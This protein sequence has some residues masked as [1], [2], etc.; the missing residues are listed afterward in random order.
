MSTITKA[1]KVSDTVGNTGVDCEVSMGAI[2]QL[3]LVHKSF[4]FDATDLEDPVTFFTEALHAAKPGR[5]FPIFGNSA[6]VQKLGNNKEADVTAT[7]DD[8]TVVPIRYGMVNKLFSTTDGGLC[9]AK[10]LQSFNRSGYAV[11]QID[12][13]GRMLVRKNDDGTY[14]GLR[15][16]NIWSPS[17]DEADFKN[18][19]FTN[20]QVS[21]SPQEYVQRGVILDGGS[22][23]SDLMGLIDSEIV[24]GVGTTAH[25]DISI[26]SECAETDLIAEFSTDWNDVTNFIVT[27]KA[28]GVVITITGVTIVGGKLRLAGTF[29]SAATYHV[30]GA[31][32]D[33]LFGND[34]EGIEVITGIDILIP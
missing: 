32:P 7:L 8:G 11:I 5:V 14:G 10:A 30:E 21:Y 24:D 31:A 26:R 13:F 2:V 6:P 4:S 18:P 17:P 1:C 33:I 15:T 28:T 20:F 27:N 16:T 34:I 19:G 3:L 22:Q 25:L 29:V 9:F 23:L 12:S